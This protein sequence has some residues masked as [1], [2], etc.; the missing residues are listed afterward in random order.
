MSGQQNSHAYSSSVATITTHA[1]SVNVCAVNLGSDS[2][3]QFT[4][5][6]KTDD[7]ECIETGGLAAP[8]GSGPR[9]CKHY[10][11]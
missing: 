6:S 2:I 4:L 11:F 10:F 1:S 7:I 3:T 8:S 9:S 5:T